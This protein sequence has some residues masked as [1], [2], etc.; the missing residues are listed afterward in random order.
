[1]KR[2]FVLLTAVVISASI[3]RAGDVKVKVTLTTAPEEEATTTF[4]P[5]TEKIYAIF[6]TKGITSGDKVRGVLIA[7]DVGDAAPAKTKVLEKTLTLEEDTSDGD[8]NFSKPDKGWPAGKYHIDIY[9][10]DELATSAKF[11]V[12]D[13]AKS[14]K[15]D[16][17]EESSDSKKSKDED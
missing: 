14:K 1:M 5:A 13:S 8:F 6:K 11:T 2:I 15:A 17:D 16:E 7:D 12:K 3:A 4:S 10:N 9:V